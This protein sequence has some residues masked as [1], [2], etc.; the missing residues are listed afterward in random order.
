M[1]LFLDL[2]PAPILWIENTVHGKRT[3]QSLCWYFMR[4]LVSIKRQQPVQVRSYLP[5]LTT[6][7]GNA[8][9]RIYL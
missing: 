5:V 4:I 6:S 1:F 7:N 8:I 3:L 9:W 2:S